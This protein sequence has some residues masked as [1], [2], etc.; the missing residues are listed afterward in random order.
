M[1]YSYDQEI[2]YKFIADTV[3]PLARTP[4]SSYMYNGDDWALP[5]FVVMLTRVY[6]EGCGA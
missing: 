3:N 6:V 5:L 2:Q 1:G 4:F